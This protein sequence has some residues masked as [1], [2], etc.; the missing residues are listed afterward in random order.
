VRSDRVIAV[1]E[2]EL[3]GGG[4]GFQVGVVHRLG[5]PWSWVTLIG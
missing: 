4:R 1:S 5:F 2:V 3:F